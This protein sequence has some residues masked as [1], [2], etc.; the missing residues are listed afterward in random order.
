MASSDANETEVFAL[1]IGCW[2]LLRMGTFNPILE[3]D[4]LFAIQWGS[5]KA[6][7]PW[8]LADWVEEVQDISR[9]AEAF[10]IHIHRG[11]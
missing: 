8:R 5:G 11:K 9:Q 4:S 3:G 7:Q 10:F 6:I 1:L 2:E